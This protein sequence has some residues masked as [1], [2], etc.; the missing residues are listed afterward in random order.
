MASPSPYGSNVIRIYR[1]DHKWLARIGDDDDP[2]VIV[3]PGKTPYSAMVG[4]INELLEH[5][6]RFDPEWV[7]PHRV[8]PPSDDVIIALEGM[9]KAKPVTAAQARPSVN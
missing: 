1:G 9:I 8:E 5:G 4:L 7:P 6:Y 2:N 3:V